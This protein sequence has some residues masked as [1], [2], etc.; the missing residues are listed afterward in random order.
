MNAAVKIFSSSMHNEK[1]EYFY[2]EFLLPAVR[3]NIAE[4]KRLNYHYYNALMKGLY[5]PT[6]W[7]K[8]ILFELCKQTDATLKE[9]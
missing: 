1:A 8:G 2:R 6:A 9:A 7:F 4:D 3:K 5:K